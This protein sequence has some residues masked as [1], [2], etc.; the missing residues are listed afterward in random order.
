MHLKGL[1]RHFQKMLLFTMLWLNALKI[2]VFEIKELLNFSGVSI[3]F[4]ILIA[5]IS[6]TVAQTTIN[7][8]IFW[9]TVI[10]TIRSIYK[11]CFNRLR[12]LAEVS[13]KLQK[14]HFFGQFKDHNS[15]RNHRNYINDPIFVYFF[16]SVCQI[17]FYIWKW[18]K[19]IFLWSPLWS[20]LVC[21]I[22]Q[23][24]AKATDLDS[25]L[26]FSRK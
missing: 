24:W 11:N 14:M 26:Y 25:P 20:I 13:T 1:V 12:F 3:V 10:R 15:G 19:F 22:P 5:N 16:C 23:F 9:K 17:H 18:S 4:D 8:I 2:L 7:H 6:W 21:K